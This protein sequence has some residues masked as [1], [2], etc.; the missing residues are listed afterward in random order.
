[1]TK[2]ENEIFCKN[3]RTRND[4]QNNEMSL[5][6]QNISLA[7]AYVPYQNWQNIYDIDDGFKAGTIF[8]DLDKPFL[9]Y[10]KGRQR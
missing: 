2:A 1:M 5:F 3:C 8:A 10:G 9:G 6:P 7:M 4:V